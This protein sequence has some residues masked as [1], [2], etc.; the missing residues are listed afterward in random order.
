MRN[1]P[2]TVRD[3][4]SRGPQRRLMTCSALAITRDDTE[5]QREPSAALT[6]S[7]PISLILPATCTLS[8][9]AALCGAAGDTVMIRK[10]FRSSCPT[11]TDVSST[12]SVEPFARCNAAPIV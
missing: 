12:G 3:R 5:A 6:S 2:S 4:E 8:G 9:G 11:M 1:P 10:R 7:S